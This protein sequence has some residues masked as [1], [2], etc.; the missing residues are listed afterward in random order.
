MSPTPLVGSGG[1][2]ASPTSPYHLPPHRDAPAVQ[3]SGVFF[4]EMPMVFY[5][6]TALA[7]ACC[8]DCRDAIRLLLDSGTVAAPLPSPPSRPIPSTCLV[9]HRH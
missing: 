1:G 2:G 9:T 7:Y 6:S 3:C 5:G 8:F 4:N